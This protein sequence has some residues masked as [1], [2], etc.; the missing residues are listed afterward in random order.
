MDKNLSY[1]Y[2]LI[3]TDGI[4]SEYSRNRGR[5]AIELQ[6][7]DV[8]IL[9]KIQSLL[10]CTSSLRFRQRDTNFKKG[11]KSSILTIFD[12]KFREE[13]KKYGMIS[14][15]KDEVIFPPI[16][17][18]YS[19]IDYIRGLLDGDGSIGVT[20]QNI[21]YISFITKSEKIADYYIDALHKY[22]NIYKISSRNIR[23]NAFN[24]MVTNENAQFWS[25]ILYYPECLS[26]NRKY[27]KAQEV[28]KWQR[29]TTRK[30]IDF[31]RKKWT[32]E[33][34][35]VILE[36]SLNEAISLLNRTEQSIKLRLWRLNNLKVN[37]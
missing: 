31:T 21:P 9:Y 34:D 18:Q 25:R 33:E 28:I 27:L 10:S 7:G 15:K 23:D 22:L 12:L 36:K 14:G 26:L 32:E 20:S 6:E 37:N 4:F 19:E 3:Q 30:K 35:I 2:G 11:Y 13:L 17:T 1:I 5:I 16:N 29:P 8:D 24:I